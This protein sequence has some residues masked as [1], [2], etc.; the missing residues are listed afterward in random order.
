MRDHADR[1]DD[2]FHHVR[3]HMEEIARTKGHH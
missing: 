2:H 3:K 1:L